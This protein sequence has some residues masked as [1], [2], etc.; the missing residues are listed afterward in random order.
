M[1]KIGLLQQNSFDDVDTYCGPEKQ[2]KLLKI[3]VDFY[4][5]GQQALKEG[6]AL[7][8]IREMSVVTMILK[9]R[10]EV[11]DDEIPKLDQLESQMKEQFKSITGVTVQ[12]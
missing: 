4:K 2:Y 10:M 3:L 1:I 9:A 8:D 7:S 6:A 11:K 12:N 5:S